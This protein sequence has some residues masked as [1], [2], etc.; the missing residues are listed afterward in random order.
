MDK[1]TLRQYRALLKEQ[2]LNDKAIDKLYDR[3]AKVPTV[4]GKVVGHW[5]K[6]KS[7]KTKKR[8]TE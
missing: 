1:K 3:A 6:R 7:G 2:I 4:M 5:Q 8:T